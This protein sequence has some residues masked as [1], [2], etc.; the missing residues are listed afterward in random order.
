MT[1]PTLIY[2]WTTLLFAGLA[3]MYCVRAKRLEE[4][5]LH[6]KEK[7]KQFITERT[8]LGTVRERMRN[9]YGSY[10]IY[11]IVDI[12]IRNTEHVLPYATASYMVAD[13]K[14]ARFISRLR[15]SVSSS[16]ITHL[17][18]TMFNSFSLI[19][20]DPLPVEMLEDESGEPLN[21]HNE[22]VPLSQFTIPLVI[23]QVVYGILTFSS[24]AKHAFTKEQMEIMYNIINHTMEAYGQIQLVIKAEKSKLMTMIQPLSDGII[25]SDSNNDIISMND[26]A[27]M[28][29]NMNK[30]PSAL[31]DII[32]TFP[33]EEGIQE[34]V[35]A[36]LRE[37]KEFTNAKMLLN[38]R[39]LEVTITPVRES[40]LHAPVGISILL[41]DIS[42][43]TSVAQMKEDFTNIMVHELRSP[44]T[45][46]K[47]SSQLIIT[48]DDK[49][50]SEERK[51]LLNLIHEQSK[52]LLDEVAMI[53]DAAKL[54]AGVFT[55]DKH[56]SDLRSV[57]ED[58]VK[59]F[60]TQAQNK[61]ISLVSVIDPRLEHF[62]F[63]ERYIALVLNNLISNSLKFAPVG[64]KITVIAQKDRDVARV[65]VVDN[66]IGI[67]KDKQADLFHKF[68]Q[69]A[70]ASANIGTGLG[71][72][73]VKGVIE[74]HGG[75]ISLA[76]DLGHGTT[77]CFTLPIAQASSQT[78]SS[79]G[80]HTMAIHRRFNPMH[81]SIDHYVAS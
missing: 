23:N 53:L 47:A 28:L 34:Q 19:H 45:A 11:D 15:K 81:S 33:Q 38:G 54:H 51:K 26:S 4:Q 79:H 68:S 9:N 74:A 22:Q 77:V 27:K 31:E 60:T 52:K 25:L 43:Q 63:D 67:P 35:A 29:L 78:S 73:I 80:E 2:L 14:T 62:S 46:I 66:G 36:A 49:F 59:I 32:A 72:Y 56:D 58:A 6:H 30:A 37:Y 13:R 64:G 39:T 24:P 3:V 50:S 12:I 7:E 18:T 48:Q 42:T 41:H 10:D 8:T 57:I 20:T 69:V 17:K 71:L 61:Y 16:Y 65:S 75:H 70:T 5:L 1:L 76:S 55:I 44:L 21:D 40:E